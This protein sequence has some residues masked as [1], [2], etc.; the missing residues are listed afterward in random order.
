MTTS[1]DE[2]DDDDDD[3]APAAR[4]RAIASALALAAASSAVSACAS[5]VRARAGC[6]ADRSS[7]VA[8]AAYLGGNSRHGNAAARRQRVALGVGAQQLQLTAAIADATDLQRARLDLGRRR[9]QRLLRVGV[10]RR[11]GGVLGGVDERLR[12]RC[13]RFRGIEQR[14][15]HVLAAEFSVC[16]AVDAWH[17]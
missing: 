8:A 5:P 9:P 17:T 14:L 7:V 12:R 13:K 11:L 2:D 3:D 6:T 10:A 4:R 15:T 1:D 16:F